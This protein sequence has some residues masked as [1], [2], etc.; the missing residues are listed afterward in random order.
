MRLEQTI[1]NILSQYTEQVQEAI[2]EAAAET[3]KET[4][5]QLKAQSPR[6]TGRYA[7]AW[8][9]KRTPQGYVI[10]NRR[11][12]L[13]HLLEHGHAKR[14]GGRVEG[15]KHIEPA[16]TFAIQSFEGKV[17]GRLQ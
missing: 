10:Y 9:R 7:K 16:E 12:Y 4:V 13:T 17:R 14:G 5:Q 2:E 1:S 8:T 15:H 6:R 11:Y 3:T